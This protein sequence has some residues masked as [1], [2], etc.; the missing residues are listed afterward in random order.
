MINLAILELVL[1][2]TLYSDEAANGTVSQPTSE[3]SVTVTEWN[4]STG[5]VTIVPT[6]GWAG[7]A[8]FQYFIRCTSGG[9]STDSNSVTVSYVIEPNSPD[10][11]WVTISDSVYNLNGSEHYILIDNSSNA[12]A[13]M[14]SAADFEDGVGFTKKVKIKCLHDP[15]G[16][17]ASITNTLGDIVDNTIPASAPTNYLFS[18]IGE[19]IEIMSDGTDFYVFR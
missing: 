8:T 12:V 15:G 17:G 13:L 7:T 1:L 3:G 9:V 10:F 16:F 4:Q 6:A 11:P 2:I 19:S 14:A 18:S 5:D